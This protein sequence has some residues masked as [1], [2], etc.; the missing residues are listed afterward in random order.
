VDH[1]ILL[2]EVTIHFPSSVNSLKNG[3]RIHQMQ[4][5]FTISSNN[6]G[7]TILKALGAHQTPQSI[8]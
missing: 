1:N 6:R 7:P 4:F 3:I 8:W 5:K 2:H